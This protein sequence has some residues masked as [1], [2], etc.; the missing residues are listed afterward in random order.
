M[1]IL[2]G[3]GGSWIYDPYE[4]ETVFQLDRFHIYQEIKRKIK[5]KKV[6]KKLTK[7]LE[8]EKPEEM[9]EYII[10]Y[11]DSVDSKEEND[12]ESANARKLYEYLNNNKEGLLPYQ[13]RGIKIPEAP[14]GIVYKNMGV[15]KIKIVQQ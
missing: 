2:N 7:L 5:D 6:Q 8:E 1:R 4:P 10:M 11:A 12:K 9:L 13:K 3:D 14:K 15:R